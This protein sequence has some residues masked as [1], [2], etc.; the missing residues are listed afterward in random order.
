MKCVTRGTPQ[1]V[2][3]EEQLKTTRVLKRTIEKKTDSRSFY[4]AF[5]PFMSSKG[6]SDQDIILKVGDNTVQKQCEVAEILAGYFSRIAEGIGDI[7]N[8][9]LKDNIMNPDSVNKI[10]E[11]QSK[12]V[13]I[14]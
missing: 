12:H 9:F 6:K 2:L 14:L 4:K 13:Q 11:K 5:S 8:N 7:P 1:L 3:G 10:K